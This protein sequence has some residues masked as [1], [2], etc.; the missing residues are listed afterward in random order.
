[1]NKRNFIVFS[2]VC[3]LAL[4]SPV[5][6]KQDKTADGAK[7]NTAIET[8]SDENSVNQEEF[9]IKKYSKGKLFAFF[10]ILLL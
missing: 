6:A 9:D 7:N 5:F 8:V 10:R 4:S 1:M 2:I 3:F